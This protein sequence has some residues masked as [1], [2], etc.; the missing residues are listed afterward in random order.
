MKKTPLIILAVAVIFFILHSAV[1][2]GP[3]PNPDPLSK[4]AQNVQSSLAALPSDKLVPIVVLLKDQAN[5]SQFSASNHPTRQAN[6]IQSLQAQA[7]AAQAPLRSLIQTRIQEGQATNPI[8]FWIFNGF[9]LSAT[10]SLVLE[11]ASMPE[12]ASISL[13]VTIPAPLSPQPALA[14]VAPGS[15]LVAIHAPEVWGLGDTGMNVVVASLDTGVDATHPDLAASWRGGRDSWFDPYGQHAAP[16][17]MNGHGTS[18][19]GIILG[20]S[21]SG[22]AIGVAPGAKWIAAKVFDDQGVASLS[23]IHLSFQW[24]LDPSGNPAAPDA[25][26]VVNNSWD[27]SSIGCDLSY[28]ADLQALLAAG[29]VTV[30]AAGN[31]G[32]GP[33]TDLSP[34]NYPEAFSVGAVDNTGLIASFSSRGPTSCGQTAALFPD[35][36]APGVSIN[37]ADLHGL[38]TTVSGTSFAA[39]HIT[40]VIALLL[41]ASPN[42]SPSQV[43]SAIENTATDLGNLGPDNTYGYG[44]VNALAAYQFISPVISTSTPTITIPPTA[45]FTPTPTSIPQPHPSAPDRIFLPFILRLRERTPHSDAPISQ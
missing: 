39:P 32:P 21:A 24:L 35:V 15:N 31:S 40:G 6:I 38:Y 34:A 7:V 18:T 9:S 1:Q 23:A 8:Y 29:I 28:Q 19:M 33:S 12:V 3:I 41:S 42:L 36:V 25:P 26:Q 27:D 11:L 16:V 4:I 5:L 43:E 20:S 30:F 44:L 10:Q 14:P 2:A 37:T 45:T 22:T 17:D 13:D